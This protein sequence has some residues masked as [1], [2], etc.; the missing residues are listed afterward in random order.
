MAL[1]R[2]EQGIFFS[3]RG[4]LSS[5]AGGEGPRLLGGRVQQDCLLKRVS[6]LPSLQLNS[7]SS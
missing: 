3:V 5:L 6:I 7:S 4:A 1:A 2:E